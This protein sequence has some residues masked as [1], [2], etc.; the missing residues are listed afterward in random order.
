MKRRKNISESINP[1]LQDLPKTLFFE[2]KYRYLIFCKAYE[3]SSSLRGIGRE[4]G[5]ISRA[6]LNGDIRDMWIG[7]R[8]IP[9]FRIEQLFK[10]IN[11]PLHGIASK[12]VSK[13]EFVRIEDWYGT[14]KEYQKTKQ[15]KEMK[16]NDK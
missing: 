10:F 8:G 3:K 4:M 7:K 15:E 12:L 16:N 2:E 13:Q 14:Y 6:G 9:T 5:Y 1:V 11:M